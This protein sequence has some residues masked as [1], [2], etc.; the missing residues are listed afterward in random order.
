MKLLGRAAVLLLLCVLVVASA[1]AATSTARARLIA[2]ARQA[3]GSVLKVRLDNT[4]STEIVTGSCLTLERQVGRRWVP[5]RYTHGVRIACADDE[6]A[7][8]PV[9]PGAATLLSTPLYDDLPAGHYRIL[10]RYTAEEPGGGPQRP[11]GP[12]AALA[13]TSIVVSAFR[14]G[15]EPHLSRTRL[16][17][18]ALAAARADGDAHPRLVQC[19]ENIE[20][21]DALVDSGDL[22]NEWSWAYA[23]A[24][25]GRFVAAGASRPPGAAAPQGT[26]ITLEIDARTGQSLGFGIGSHYPRLARL[27]AVDTL[28]AGGHPQF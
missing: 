24:M 7:S 2:V 19:A 17:A 14:P 13:S 10:A 5:I 26:V 28:E 18:I 4:G 12:H 20:S 3:A 21:R 22:V 6:P 11:L 27:G 9:D 16:L 23:I 15:P 1:G 25:R 8:Q